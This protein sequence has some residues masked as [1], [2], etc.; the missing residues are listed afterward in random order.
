M[1]AA[2]LAVGAVVFPASAPC[3]AASS[4]QTP[5]RTGRLDVVVEDPSGAVVPQA[6]VEIR[7]RA[8]D[9][10]WTPVP[11]A[12]NRWVTTAAPGSYD[13]RVTAP[14]FE[15]QTLEAVPVSTGG[16]TRVVRLAL[17]RLQ[18]EVRVARD[19]QSEA[20]DPRG[21]STF[22]SREQIDALPDDPGDMSRALRALAPPGA[23]IRIDGFTSGVLP[24]KA[25]ILSIRIPRIDA[26]AAEDHGGLGTF[27]A[28]DIVT[29]PG[30]GQWQ[31]SAGFSGHDAALDARNPLTSGRTPASQ[32]GGDAAVDGPI[33]RDRASLAFQVRAVRESETATIRAELPGNVVVARGITRPTSDFTIDTRAITALGGDRT[34]RAGFSVIGHQVRNAGVGEANLEDR[35]YDLQSLERTVRIALGGPWRRRWQTAS[36]VELRW[37]GTRSQSALE[38]PTVQVLGAFTSG[39]AQATS[40]E[41]AWQVEA[42]T[43]V[44]YARG[45]HAVRGGVLAN[46]DRRS[47]NRRSNYEGTYTFTS[48]DA[49]VAG[50]PAV[51]TRRSGDGRLQYTDARLGAYLQDDYRIARSLLVSYGLRSEWQNLVTATPSVLPRVG[52]T[53]SPRR[54]GSPTVRASWGLVRE[55][56]AASV[57]EQ[58]RLVDG[59]H[60]SDLRVIAPSYPASANVGVIQPRE[61]YLLGN[62]LE[63][64]RGE[65][66]VLG[67]EQQLSPAWRLYVSSSIRR[68]TGLLRGRNLNPVVGGQHRDVASGNVIAA[69]GDAGLR[70]RALTA[71]AVYAPQHRH[72]DAALTYVLNRSVTNTTGAFSVPST[73][74]LAEEWG[75][76][77]STHAAVASVTARWRGVVATLMPRWRSGIP[78]TVTLPEPGD[79]GLLNVRPTGVGRNASRTPAQADIGLRLTYIVGLGSTRE[80]PDP[81]RPGNAAGTPP[82]GSVSP[83]SRRFHLEFQAAARN[84]TN[85]PNYVAMGSVLGAPSFGRPVGAA[86]ARRVEGGIRFRF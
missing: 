15:M 12:N 73:A 13:L 3:L 1:L 54:T 14:G 39:G 63:P 70:V 56:L 5:P 65:A 82:P 40:G 20:L 24:S 51:F 25:Q 72:V 37:T 41:R 44:D 18:A 50:M 10:E 61:R 36:R 52:L 26:L 21:F 79:D 35:R 23:V 16:T 32:V 28:V 6:T 78:Y 9:G 34:L 17:S 76:V 57:Y 85:R 81:E 55:W 64:P 75:P 30:G 29:R 49:F 45:G 19:R 48:L 43:D 2:L 69:E 80:P 42:A 47:V 22:L 8:A 53:W 27:S 66:L 62:D 31:G 38:A 58:A 7:V 84:L 46:T 74:D 68:G 59:V 71:Q 4:D 60:Q 33:L 67:F 83:G 11:V 86:P 77:T